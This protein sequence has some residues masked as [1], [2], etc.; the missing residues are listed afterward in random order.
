MVSDDSLERITMA[1]TV[2]VWPVPL[3]AE[4]WPE[5]FDRDGKTWTKDHMTCAASGEVQCAEYT[6]GEGEW[7][8]VY[9]E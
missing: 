1:A 7:L 5:T 3:P 4:D 6:A 8:I 9:N 2:L